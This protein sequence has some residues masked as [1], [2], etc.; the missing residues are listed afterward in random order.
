MTYTVREV[1]YEDLPYLAENLRGRDTAELVATY[2]HNNVLEGLQA[3]W[4]NSEEC[5]V[6]ITDDHKPIL[7][8]GIRQISPKCAMIWACCTPEIHRY[9]LS[10]IR[11]S[12]LTIKRWFDERPECEYFINF[13]HGNNDLHHDWLRW[14]GA[15]MHPPVPY[16]RL[17]HPFRPFVIWRSTYNV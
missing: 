7:L 11:N 15:D 12:R 13:T 2:G 9:K 5:L 17:G 16:G 3:S 4:R 10:F 6:G 1:Q 14:L 8:W